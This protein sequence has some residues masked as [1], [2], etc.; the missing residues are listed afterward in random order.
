MNHAWVCDSAQNSD[1]ENDNINNGARV[2]ILARKLDI[3]SNGNAVVI[4]Q[5]KFIRRLFVL[6]SV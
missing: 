2:C 5:A 1:V 6:F 3:N 4:V